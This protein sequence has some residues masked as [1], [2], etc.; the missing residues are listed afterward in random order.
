MVLYKDK[1]YVCVGILRQN[2]RLYIVW[3]PRLGMGKKAAFNVLLFAII[4]YEL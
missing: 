2:E 1:I 4:F 3:V